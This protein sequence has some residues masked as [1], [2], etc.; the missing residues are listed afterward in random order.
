MLVSALTTEHG[1][2]YAH[3][4]PLSRGLPT[5]LSS[6]L[7][8]LSMSATCSEGPPARGKEQTMTLH[9]HEACTAECQREA[10]ALC[11]LGDW[12]QQPCIASAHKHGLHL[13]QQDHQ[14][15]PAP[16]NLLTPTRP[17][18]PTA[19]CCTA[20]TAIARLSFSAAGMSLGSRR[21]AENWSTSR[22]VMV[23]RITAPAQ[24]SA[25]RDAAGQAPWH[26]G[27]EP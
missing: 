2:S 3:L 15:P 19:A 1:A 14:R 4:M 20:L 26:A 11:H 8:R 12:P 13:Q 16:P 17:A 9:A 18:L 6:A 21:C 5:K 25:P 22:T 24:G 10:L 7:I 27:G 23:S